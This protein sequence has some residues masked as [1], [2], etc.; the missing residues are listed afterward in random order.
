MINKKKSIKSITENYGL[1]IIFVIMM[2]GFTIA[3]PSFLTLGNLSRVF[4]SNIVITCVSIGT[5]FVLAIDEFDMS[6]GYMIGMILVFGA[7]LSGKGI[8]VVLVL[9]AM[10][11]MGV[12]AG[13][14]NAVLVVILKMNSAIAT[15]GIGIFYYGVNLIMSNGEIL[16][17]DISPV[18]V[19][20]I[21]GRLFNSAAP[22]NPVYFVFVIGIVLAIIMAITTFGKHV[23]AVGGNPRAAHLSGISVKKTK[24]AAFVILGLCIALAAVILLGQAKAANP[25]RGQE[26]LMP[27]YAMT[28]LSLT[29][30]K[31]GHYNLP[32]VLLA[33]V[34]VSIGLNGLSLLGTPYW[35]E[36]VFYGIILI[37]SVLLTKSDARKF[38]Q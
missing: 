14:I 26:Y 24:I 25:A 2:I 11:A 17:K 1:V 38:K 8:P 33:N 27:A 23:Y 9:L 37:V 22:T 5:F 7:W 28:F 32:G 10:F 4:V 16:A 21:Q 35:F 36:S 3:K 12:C 20:N 6:I 29:V 15:L 19:D 13:L 18:L 31:P 34:V 30:F